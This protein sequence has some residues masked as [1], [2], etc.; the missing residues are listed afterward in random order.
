MQ[1]CVAFRVVARDV[2]HR[3]ILQVEKQ[4]APIVEGMYD[5]GCR[6]TFTGPDAGNGSCNASLLN[7][8]GAIVAAFAVTFGA[9][10]RRAEP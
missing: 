8:S 1:K 5:I 6:F 7:N 3:R 9:T 4:G 10:R 2:E